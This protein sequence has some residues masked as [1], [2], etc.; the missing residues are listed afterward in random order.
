MP[1]GR[2]FRRGRKAPY[3]FRSSS[4][5][6]GQGVETALTETTL[7]LMKSTLLLLGIA[8]VSLTL[9]ACK[10]RGYSGKLL[11]PNPS[12]VL[13]LRRVM[14]AA[15]RSKRFGVLTAAFQETFPMKSP[16]LV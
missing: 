7:N 3:E 11:W 6:S 4:P 13:L 5:K 16:N 14:A 1:G 15:T 9:S 12:T 8:F 10:H 2:N